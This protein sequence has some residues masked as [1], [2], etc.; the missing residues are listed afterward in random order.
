MLADSGLIRQA[1]RKCATPEEL[2]FFYLCVAWHDVA[3]GAGSVVAVVTWSVGLT[4]SK[5]C[6]TS[7]L[8]ASFD[9]QQISSWTSFTHCLI[10]S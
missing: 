8:I 4:R 1:G 10:S 3:V 9:R 7:I 5:K 2:L 6:W